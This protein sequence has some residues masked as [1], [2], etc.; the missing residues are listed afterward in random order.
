V[1][2]ATQGP[3]ATVYNHAAASQASDARPLPPQL[4]RIVVVGGGSAGWMAAMLLQHAF[5]ARG[6]QVTVL[7]SPA[8]ETIGVGEGSTPWMRGFFETLDIEEAEWMPACNATYKAGIRFEGWSTKPGFESYF[9][10]FASMLDNR[11]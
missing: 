3:T 8:V 5:G 10:P 6:A 1:S 4:R 11:R 7:E 2:V 9:H